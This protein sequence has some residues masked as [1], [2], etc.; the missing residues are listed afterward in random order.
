MTLS[1]L[2]LSYQTWSLKAESHTWKMSTL[3]LNYII[4]FFYE[5][6]IILTNCRRMICVAILLCNIH[7]VLLFCAL[8]HV[9][10][11][12]LMFY[13]KNMAYKFLLLCFIEYVLNY[14][15]F[16]SKVMFLLRPINLLLILLRLQM[17]FWEKFS[18]CTNSI[19]IKY[20]FI[21][22]KHCCFIPILTLSI[23][24]IMQWVVLMLLIL[25]C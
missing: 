3:P 8:K 7:T 14:N 19:H 23:N 21:Q 22:K 24:K 4:S 2:F 10:S 1:S 15:N 16:L 17:L 6:Y 5:L 11:V 20:L 25:S 9:M 13:L 18:C 12:S